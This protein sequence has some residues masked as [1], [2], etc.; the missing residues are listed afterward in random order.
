MCH[1]VTTIGGHASKRTQKV[2]ERM[3]LGAWDSS[4]GEW[5]GGVVFSPGKTVTMGEWDMSLSR[6]INWWHVRRLRYDQWQ[7]QKD[8]FKTREKNL[9]QVMSA[10]WH[11]FQLEAKC[12]CLATNCRSTISDPLLWI[13]HTNAWDAWKPLMTSNK[14]S[15]KAATKK[16]SVLRSWV[17]GNLAREWTCWVGLGWN[18]LWCVSILAQKWI[19]LCV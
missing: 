13:G 3:G 12:W 10:R 7:R 15:D 1:D 17:K 2:G 11:P 14:V 18:V 9:L 5:V 6:N 8:M 19:L 4:R 16:V